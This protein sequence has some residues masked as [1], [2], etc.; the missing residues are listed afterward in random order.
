VLGQYRACCQV[1]DEFSRLTRRAA[2][3]RAAAAQ[4]LD[5][6]AL[7]RRSVQDLFTL[8]PNF[9]PNSFVATE[10]YR[11]P[12]FRDLLKADLKAACAAQVDYPTGLA[13]GV[14]GAEPTSAREADTH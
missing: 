4:H 7:L 8:D 2:A 1:V 3:Y 11:D 10:F 13:A 6:A 9:A 12:K 14:A 5:D